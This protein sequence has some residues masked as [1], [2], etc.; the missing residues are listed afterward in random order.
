MR[1]RF[2]GEASQLTDGPIPA[3]FLPLT[4]AGS[5]APVSSVRP[6]PHPEPV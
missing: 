6:M 5:T 4:Q 1:R 3:N 2:L